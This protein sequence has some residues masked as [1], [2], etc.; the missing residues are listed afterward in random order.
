MSH[1]RNININDGY[2]RPELINAGYK[3]EPFNEKRFRSHFDTWRL[4]T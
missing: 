4:F 3:R 2:D 1:L